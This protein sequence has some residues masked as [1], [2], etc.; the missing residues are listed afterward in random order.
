MVRKTIF[1]VAE[2]GSPEPH[3]PYRL[4]LNDSSGR[5]E[6]VLGQCSSAGLAYSLYYSAQ[7]E[8]FGRRLTLRLGHHVL[9]STPAN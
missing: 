7:R 2:L 8:Y 1:E 6:R 4:E 9:A 3:L 5:L